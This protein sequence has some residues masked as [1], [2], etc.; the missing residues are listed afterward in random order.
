MRGRLVLE[1]LLRVAIYL[2]L[3]LAAWQLR[4]LEPVYGL[5][6]ML[7]VLCANLSYSLRYFVNEFRFDRLIRGRASMAVAAR[8]QTRRRSL[9]WY[10]VVLANLS[11]LFVFAFLFQTFH[12]WEGQEVFSYDRPLGYVDW[13]LYTVDC[14]FKSILDLPEI[15]GLHLRNIR[16]H[17]LAGGAIVASVRLMIY[18]LL[19]TA[20]VR[21]WNRWLLLRET[22]LAMNTAPRLAGRRLVRMGEAALAPLDAALAVPGLLTTASSE[23]DHLVR[24]GHSEALL[25]VALRN[26]TLGA[27]AERQN[28]AVFLGRLCLKDPGSRPW[29]WT[30]LEALQAEPVAE[31]RTQI[32]RALGQLHDPRLR[33][34]LREQL[35]DQDPA[36]RC[37]TARVLGHQADR[38]AVTALAGC[39]DDPE[40]SVRVAVIRA[41]GRIG[42]AHSLHSLRQA[43]ADPAPEVHREAL[44][45]LAHLRDPRVGPAL[46]RLLQ[47]A[48]AKT[49]LRALDSIGR[50]RPT[51]AGDALAACLDDAA[52]LVRARALRVLAALH[53][54]RARA[55]I[56]A[57]KPD[58]ASAVRLASAVVLAEDPQSEVV[59]LLEALLRDG[60][61]RVRARAI[62]G[63]GQVRCE[64]SNAILARLLSAD[65]I[66][67][68]VNAA[69]ALGESGLSAAC[70]PLGKAAADGSRPHLAAQ[71]AR[72]L[73]KLQKPPARRTR[74]RKQPQASAAVS[75]RCG[76]SQRLRS[77]GQ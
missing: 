37:E 29:F 41:L 66:D 45:S 1:A 57:R 12:Q 3:F 55:E 58:A 20:V 6:L 9:R 60:D 72:S 21:R 63:L 23:S 44:V 32:V 65:D 68:A 30:M 50:L 73:G 38:G 67:D 14:T 31:V 53:P 76:G 51:D 26:L 47:A 62:E 35:D 59:P 69:R 54:A 2:L 61:G 34:A 11:Q 71:A 42:D 28:A 24:D 56:A 49:R 39:L 5:V 7:G 18:S 16:H 15:F 75:R 10:W 40:S 48:D 25:Q 77:C 52:V 46:C 8:I 33:M 43:L 64:A 22:V 19:V 74:G 4:S 36:V 27:R 70:Q 17:G 13:L